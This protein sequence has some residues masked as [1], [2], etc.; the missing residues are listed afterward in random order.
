[1]QEY[2]DKYKEILENLVLFLSGLIVHNNDVQ[3][4]E[5]IFN[6]L[7]VTVF[8]NLIKGI[9][10]SYIHGKEDQLELNKSEKSDYE[11]ITTGFNIYIFLQIF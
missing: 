1:M 5:Q 10:N 3:N 9:F 6:F 8:A 2:A 11:I 7:D 4:L